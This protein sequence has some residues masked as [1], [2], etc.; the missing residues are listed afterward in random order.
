MD[1]TGILKEGEIFCIVEVDGKPK[2]IT[3]KELIITRSLVL[4]KGDIQIM[5]GVTVPDNS[6]LMNLCSC[7]CFSQKG[8]RD[9]PSKLSGGDLDGDLYQII[10]DPKARPEWVFPPANYH[11]PTRIELDRSVERK[12]MTDFFVQFM[13]TDQLGRIAVRHKVLADQKEHGARYEGC[14]TNI[15]YG[16]SLQPSH[17]ISEHE[18]FNKR[19]HELSTSMKERFN[20][21]L[22]YI[23]N[24]IVKDGIARSEESLAKSIACLNVAL[25]ETTYSKTGGELVSFR[26]VAAALC[27]NDLGAAHAVMRDEDDLKGRSH[28]TKIMI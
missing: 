14:V 13:A 24:C 28:A 4:H 27:L 9:L 8:K 18:V 3:G 16:Y 19:Q 23:V 6:L 25:E 15:S 22:T 11:Q 10:F 5:T 20:D 21:D 1:E 17:A 12:D 26:Y 7:I 2:V